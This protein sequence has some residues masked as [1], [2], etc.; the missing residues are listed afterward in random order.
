MSAVLERPEVSASQIATE[1]IETVASLSTI[2]KRY[3]NG[4]VALDNLSL[5]LHRGEIVALLGPNGA[6]KS[7]A[8]KLL[9]GL[10]SPTGGTVRIFSADPRHTPARLRT[11]VMLQVGKAP[12]MLR[13]REHIDLFRGYYPSPMPYP[14]IV[15]A[16]GL[17]TIEERM[18]GQLSGGQKQ[19]VLF[20]LA[21]AGDPD[22]IFLDEPTVGFDIEARRGMWAQIRSLAARGKTVLL[23]THYLEE[24]DALAHRIIVIN[25]GR[26]VCAGTPAEVKSLGSTAPGTSTSRN[27]KIIRCTTVLPAPTLLAIPGVTSAKLTANLA[28]LISTKPESTLRELLTLDQTLHSLEVQ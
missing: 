25:K 27:L 20:A 24:A 23:T 10:S 18:F 11:G 7:T 21:L 8:I 26:V 22:L 4:V 9:M 6:G 14:D 17:E 12:E 28:T 2:T 16:A 19:R 5:T 3:A 1:S 13:V 15:K